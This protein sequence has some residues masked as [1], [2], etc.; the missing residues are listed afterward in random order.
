MATPLKVGLL[1]AGGITNS[2]LPAYLEHPDRVKLTAVC[3]LDESRAQAQAKKA[4]VEAVYTDLDKMLREADIDAV[5]NCTFHPAHAPLCIAVA[6]AGKHVL[7]EKPM[8]ITV[9]ECRDM[10]AA[11][12]K[13]G[14]TLM[15]AQDLRYSR[16]AAATKR[17]IDDGK[18][19]DIIS[20]RTH[21]LAPRLPR[22]ER[23]GSPAGYDRY[24]DAEQ[25]GG[26][27]Q[28]VQV[29]HIDLLRYYVGNVKRVTGVTR[30]LGTRMV[31]GA[32]DL[33]VA[34]L[35]FENGAVGY[36]FSSPGEAPEDKTDMA[37][38]A[39][40][41]SD[42]EYMVYG[43]AGTIHSSPESVEEHH[44]FGR[45]LFAPIAD[46]PVD[47]LN[48]FDRRRWIHPP[49]EPIDTSGTGLPSVK[50]FVNEILHFEEC[51][52][53]GKEPISSGRDNIETVKIIHGIFESSRT[54]K[55]VNLD[56]L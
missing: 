30:S 29:H 47:R 44:H 28:A 50:P 51:I 10:I 39:I 31:N 21:L 43:T 32:E 14:V 3:D 45:I 12:D 17:F 54:G 19:G 53:T 20:A 18:L 7:V 56:D 37:A 49:F 1:G 33:V 36:L 40:K 35:E 2:H 22:V 27:M 34:I 16:E 4:G 46:Q 15:V 24:A 6:E 38:S 52:R 5:D 55:A 48:Y 9:Q 41:H 11:A 23:G 8:A 26:V 42:R 25:G 13:A